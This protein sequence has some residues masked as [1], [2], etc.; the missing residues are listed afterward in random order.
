MGLMNSFKSWRNE[1][2]DPNAAPGA[3]GSRQAKDKSLANSMGGTSSDDS[4]L[5]ASHPQGQLQ[6]AFDKGGVLP[7]I[8]IHDGNHRMIVAEAGERVLTPEQNHEYEAQHPDARK[9]PMMAK[10]YDKGGNVIGGTNEPDELYDGGGVVGGSNESESTPLGNR[11]ANRA[12]EI[13][14]QGKALHNPVEK[15]GFD[16]KQANID[17]YKSSLKQDGSGMRP[18]APAAVDRVHPAGQPYG[19]R[20]GSGEKR[21][22]TD[23]M[24]KPLGSLPMYDEGGKVQTEDEKE[25]QAAEE[26]R[27]AEGMRKLASDTHNQMSPAYKVPEGAIPVYDDGGAVKDDDAAAKDAALKQATDEVMNNAPLGHGQPQEREEA[28]NNDMRRYPAPQ[29]PARLQYDTE[30][31]VDESKGVAELAGDATMHSE[32]AP[33][34]PPVMNRDNTEPAFDQPMISEASAKTP[35]GPKAAPQGTEMRQLPGQVPA[36]EAPGQAALD[37]EQIDPMDVVQKDKLAAMKKGTEGLTD[38]GT[39]LIHEKAL[40]A[41][42]AGPELTPETPVMPAYTGTERIG[43]GTPGEAEAHKQLQD[44]LRDY[45]TRIQSAMDQ[46][47]PEGDREAASLQLA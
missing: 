39:S 6:W 8:N 25:M 35:L 29:K 42:M 4:M 17:A 43:K 36:E 44:K 47:T 1:G 15:Q 7:R 31:P 30:N 16:E 26:A 41:S 3:A 9:N 24:R 32:N 2:V 19:S 45:D 37:K 20:P 12:Q 46:G 11:I 18:Y 10:V 13:Y 28:Q 33:L 40:K 14:E 34:G 23:E 27:R 5:D 38:L 22:N 21:I